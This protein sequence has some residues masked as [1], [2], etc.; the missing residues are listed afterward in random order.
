MD[1]CAPWA[2]KAEALASYAKRA[3]DDELR[4]F[5]DR[6][7][8]R[9]I[10]RCGELLKQIK[11]ATGTHRKSEGADLRAAGESWPRW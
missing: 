1:E 7:Q 11:P 8:A 5:A 9:A 10:R 6:I 4:K 2:L 3:G